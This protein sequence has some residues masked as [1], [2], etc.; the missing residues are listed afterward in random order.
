MTLVIKKPKKPLCK[1]IEHLKELLEGSLTYDSKKRINDADIYLNG[2]HDCYKN[3]VN[4]NTQLKTLFNN[5]KQNGEYG[6]YVSL[7]SSF[8]NLCKIVELLDI[9]KFCDLGAGSGILLKALIYFK[10]MRKIIGYENEKILVDNSMNDYVKL[11]DI[12]DLTITDLKDFECIYFWE[13]FKSDELA[14]KF[15]NHLSKVTS[16]GQIIIYREAGYIGKY[17]DKNKKFLIINKGLLH[18]YLVN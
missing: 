4:N 7:D 13:P 16:K 5:S 8:K 2:L 6:Y 17:L 9:K 12:F 11:K 3:F 14:N 18:I 15:V 1:K 10:Q